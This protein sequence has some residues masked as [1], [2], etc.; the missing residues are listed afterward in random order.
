[1]NGSQWIT[2][3]LRVLNHSMTK[4]EDSL[5]LKTVFG[6]NIKTKIIFSFNDFMSV[7]FNGRKKKSRQIFHNKKIQICMICYYVIFV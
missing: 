1:M 2:Y 7:I 4:S 3:N 5:Y 6:Q